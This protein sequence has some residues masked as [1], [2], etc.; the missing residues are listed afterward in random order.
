MAHINFAAHLANG[1]QMRAC[2]LV[3]NFAN[4]S[5]IGGD[6]L[7]LKAIAARGGRDKLAVFIAKGAGQAINFR[8][9]GEGE[10]R[11]RIQAQ[12]PPDPRDKFRNI[13]IAEDIGEREHRHDMFDLAKFGGGGR[14]H[15]QRGGIG[16]AQFGKFSLQ[17]LITAAQGVIVRICYGRGVV[18][19]IALVMR[20]DVS[21][22]LLMLKA[23]L[24]NRTGH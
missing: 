22:Q 17:R 7:T 8:L 19:I 6:I 20:G 2:K 15:A 5:D 10:F 11:C 18:L 16:G 9:G 3:R 12:K 14:A 21:P 4:G 24:F 1:G 13:F 23:C